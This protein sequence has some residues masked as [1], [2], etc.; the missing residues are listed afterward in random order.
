M[1][2]QRLYVLVF[3]E[4][5]TRRLH[6]A[7]VTACPAGAWAAQQACNL[8]MDMGDRAGTLRFLMQ[9]RGPVFTT[10]VGE[11]FRSG[12]LRI[13]ATSPGTP[14]WK[15][16]CE[17]GSGTLR[18]ELPGRTLIA[19]EG[20]LALVLREYGAHYTGHRPHQ[21]RQQRP[22]SVGTQPVRD[23]AGVRSVRRRPVVTGLINRYHRAA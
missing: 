22:P 2:F 8:A 7:G 23:V 5:G 19:G 16:I 12:G 13:I 20:H 11:V 18:R 17:R 10:G 9:D 3:I 1:L 6:V 21:S 4:H 15:A 14:R